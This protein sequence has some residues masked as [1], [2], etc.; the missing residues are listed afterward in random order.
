MHVRQLEIG[1]FGFL[2]NLASKQLNFTIPPSYVLWLFMRIEGAV[3]LVAEQPQEGLLAYL[4]AVP[5]EGPEKSLFV[6]QLAASAGK[7]QGEAI[8]LIL[9]T[10]RDLA[11]RN[12]VKAIA[13]SM[14]PRSAA[15]RL[16]SR[17]TR[18]LIARTP[19]L[20]SALPSVVSR[21]ESEYRIEL[22]S[23]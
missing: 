8:H 18:E 12:G 11:M 3:C 19:R 14:R 21:D 10:L 23:P 20:S 4:L 17:Y 9:T 5:I 6:W 1:D 2:Q 7:A 15:Y 22:P 13:F 16:V